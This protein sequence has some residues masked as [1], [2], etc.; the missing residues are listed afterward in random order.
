VKKLGVG[1]TMDDTS[2]GYPSLPSM[3]R[4]PLNRLKVDR[5]AIG[6]LTRSAR[7]LE[8]FAAFVALAH[9]MRLQVIAEGVETEAQASVILAA[10]CDLLQGHYY[11]PAQ[12]AELLLR[13]VQ[14]L[15]SRGQPTPAGRWF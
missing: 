15:T 6:Q 4:L 9:R 11:A 3:N 12:D 8:L 5:A 1:M 14:Q 10:D 2:G 7:E 13:H